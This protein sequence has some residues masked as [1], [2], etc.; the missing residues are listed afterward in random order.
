MSAQGHPVWRCR[1]GT[2]WEYSLSRSL[3]DGKLNGILGCG[4]SQILKACALVLSGASF[5]LRLEALEYL[6]SKSLS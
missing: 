6:D 1:A 3:S 4:V 5:Y 2:C